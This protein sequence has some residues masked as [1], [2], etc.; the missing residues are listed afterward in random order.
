VV[1]PNVNERRVEEKRA[2]ILMAYRLQYD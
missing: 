2:S 1:K